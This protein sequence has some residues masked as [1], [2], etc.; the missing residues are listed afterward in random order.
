MQDPNT[1]KS[2]LKSI[3][4]NPEDVI[5]PDGKKIRCEIIS[6]TTMNHRIQSSLDGKKYLVT[7]NFNLVRLD[8]VKRTK[9]EKKLL[10]KMR[11]ANRKMQIRSTERQ[12]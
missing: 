8:K 7:E 12:A 5:S 3:D 10:K 6:P 9:A 2:D 11:H 1:F 4:F